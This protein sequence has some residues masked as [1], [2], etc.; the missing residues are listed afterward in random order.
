MKN[1]KEIAKISCFL[2][3]ALPIV[4]ETV[5]T[6]LQSHGCKVKQEGYGL[7]LAFSI[8]SGEKKSKFFLQNLLLEIATVDR[9]EEPLRF[10]E[11]LT[12]FEHFRTKTARLTESK[13]KVLFNLLKAEDV[14]AAVENIARDTKRHE[15]IRIWRFDQKN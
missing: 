8:K 11:K 14:D 15:R 9:D 13:L 4:V 5:R 12:D 7:D 1:Q 2:D 10:D 3:M 6:S